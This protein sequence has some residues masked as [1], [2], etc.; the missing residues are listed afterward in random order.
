MLENSLKIRE[1]YVNKIKAKVD[2]LSESIHLLEKVDRQLMKEQV[3]MGG[4]RL[5]SLMKSYNNLQSGGASST[6]AAASSDAKGVDFRAVQE[7]ALKKKAEILLQRDSVDLLNANIAKL[8]QGFEPI[9][10]VL[11]NVKRLIESININL[12]DLAKADPPSVDAWSALAQYNLYRNNS[13]SKIKKV[14]VELIDPSNGDIKYIEVFDAKAADNIETDGSDQDRQDI[15]D[16]LEHLLGRDE[17]EP[18]TNKKKNALPISTVQDW[19]CKA[20]KQIHGKNADCGADAAA[21]SPP[22]SPAAVPAASASAV[23]QLPEEG[24]LSATP[25]PPESPKPPAGA[26]SKY[27]FF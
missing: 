2:S 27:R 21:D 23:P 18:G 15:V 5:N 1:K 10:K 8:A 13:W 19:Y 9:N 25:G 6:L 24:G 7:A 11:N 22:S 4:A 16:Y 17:L 14:G 20:L 3:Q 12:P 26:T